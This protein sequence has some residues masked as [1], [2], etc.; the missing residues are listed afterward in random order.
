MEII[1][2]F[3]YKTCQESIKTQNHEEIYD[4]FVQSLHLQ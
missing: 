1:Y 3:V 2:L 4:E